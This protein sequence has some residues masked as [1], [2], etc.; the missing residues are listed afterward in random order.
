M[1]EQNKRAVWA[2]DLSLA[3]Q[4]ESEL[5][6]E[7]G[8]GVLEAADPVSMPSS[9]VT[10]RYAV[11]NISLEVA[12]GSYCAIL[13]R[14]GSGKSSLAKLLS[15]LEQP[16]KGRVLVLGHDSRIE[17]E[18]WRIREQTAL[19]FQNPDNQI[20]GTTVEEDIAFGPENLGKPSAEIQQL[21]EDA[22]RRVGLLEKLKEAPSSLS[23]GQKQKLALAGALAMQ[24]SL[25]ILDE[26]TSM[27]DPL[28]RKDILE[29]V[30]RLCREEG[31]TLLH[32]THHMEEAVEADQLLVLAEGHLLM[33]GRPSELFAQ[34]EALR[35]IGLDVPVHIALVQGLRRSWE[36]WG[37]P[38]TEDLKT[39]FAAQNQDEVWAVE[40][41]KCFKQGWLA[42]PASR[43]AEVRAKIGLL[44][45]VEGLVEA[46]RSERAAEAD[47]R[48]KVVVEVE[49]LSYRY[50]P[51]EG[52]PYALRD[53]HFEVREG[54]IFGIMGHTGS[55]KSTL[56]Q[57]L[58][59][60]LRAQEG[61][62]R[63]FGQTLDK[64]QSIRDIRKRVGLVF[65][66][67]EHQLFAETVK[68]DI[69]FGPLRLGR[70]LEEVEAELPALLESVGLSTAYLS[71]SPFALSGGE[72]RRVALAGVLAMNPDILVLDEPAAG[73]DPAGR[74]EMLKLVQ[75]WRRAGK[76]VILVSHSM[77]DL[78]KVC[79]RIL[80]LEEGRQLA[81][82]SPEEIF[83]QGR[84]QR[85]LLPAQ[86]A[87]LQR[88][89]AEV[90]PLLD[91]LC[92][93]EEEG[94][95]RLQLALLT[96]DVT[97]D[98]MNDITGETTSDVTTDITNNITNDIIQEEERA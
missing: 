35:D 68:E 97:G 67:P 64:N 61:Q 44:D 7:Q 4:Q 12:K 91:P 53:I 50:E 30:L 33:T 15:A 16:V 6:E 65:Q 41:L 1:L 56:I 32:V 54:E 93:H 76:T 22:A 66:Y 81:V 95:H 70:S 29:F 59:G 52:G 27:L 2:E 55:G 36:A 3:Y 40:L 75:G 57:H 90:F 45:E 24:P 58:N 62:L 38:L 89:Q 39:A 51:K 9:A 13:G 83:G 11:D 71:R 14:N 37:L 48:P 20:I 18:V 82:G 63:L 94:L 17:E 87:F 84:L 31:L 42:L 78:S 80:L 34:V 19:V 74:D 49:N 77:E 25:L 8:G 47:Q 79:N 72:K 43:R 92:F 96:S 98:V 21:V 46:E 86:F 10:R 88:L 26:A 5:G 69:A 60:L 73:L 23:G 28:A 85:E